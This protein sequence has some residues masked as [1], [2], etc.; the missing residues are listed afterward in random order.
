MRMIL[1]QNK[2]ILLNF[3]NVMYIC[4]DSKK[5][6]TTRIYYIATNTGCIL[7]KYETYERAIQVLKEIN[8][9]F[10]GVSVVTGSGQRIPSLIDRPRTYEMPGE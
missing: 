5:L 8:E 4:E 10:V 1:S 2:D 6:G 3:D 9:Y 7:G